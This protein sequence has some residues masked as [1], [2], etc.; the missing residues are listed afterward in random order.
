MS[1]LDLTIALP[2]FE[3]D[4]QV[5]RRVLRA[6]VAQAPGEVIV[7]DMSRTSVVADACEEVGGVSYVPLPDSRGVSQ[8]RN[9]CLRRAATRHVLF[10]DSDAVPDPGWAQA[11]AEGFAEERVAIVG[12]RVLPAWDR[13]PPLLLRSATASDWL[14]MF[15]LGPQP[16]RVP[17]VMGTSYAVDTERVGDA[18]FDESLGRAPGVALGHEEVRLAL[19]AQAAGWRCGYAAA[20]V[21][22]HQLPRSRATWR[23]MVRRAFVAGQE[24]HYESARL[25]PLPR[26][27]TPRDHL[28]RA[29]V[30]P[31]FLLGRVVGPRSG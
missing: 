22:R 11:M 31:A 6:T 8:S 21:V 23:S 18:P 25:Q 26:R 19:E 13:P 15:D 30:A 9:E 7:V 14:S 29:A 12:A 3:G 28:F 27:L 1:G 24:T 20:A 17:R 4:P 16:R 10:L 2:T 5:L